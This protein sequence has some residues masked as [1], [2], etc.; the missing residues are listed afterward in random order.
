MLINGYSA[1]GGDAL[2]YYFKQQGLG[3]LI[4][5]RTW[6]GLI[7]I[8]GAPPLADGGVVIPPTF[9]IYDAEGRWVVENEGVAPDVEVE[10]LPKLRAIG[11]D[12]QLERAV[13]IGL[14]LLETRGVEL[15]EQPPDPVRVRRPER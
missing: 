1:S 11:R 8:T 4:G 6:G 5:T 10:Q 14:D 13:E 12:P 2:P 7:G 3:V 15:L 9:R